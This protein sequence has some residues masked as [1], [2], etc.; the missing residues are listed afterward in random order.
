LLKGWEL[1]R[2][3][4]SAP[5]GKHNT[6]QKRADGCRTDIGHSVNQPHHVLQDS[7]HP[8]TLTPGIVSRWTEKIQEK[9]GS[10]AG[11]CF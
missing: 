3:S 10:S 9:H 7:M 11:H 5:N 8:H 2:L 1:N 4:G 6:E